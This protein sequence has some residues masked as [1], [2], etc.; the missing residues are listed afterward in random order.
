MAGSTGS[1][2][3]GMGI[4]CVILIKFERE[5]EEARWG[6]AN[7]AEE[8]FAKSRADK[9]L[10]QKWIR[11]RRWWCA[12]RRSYLHVEAWPTHV[13]LRTCAGFRFR[14]YRDRDIFLARNE[15]SSGISFRRANRKSGSCILFSYG[16]REYEMEWKFRTPRRN[17]LHN[18]CSHYSGM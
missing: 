12:L 15:S 8:R 18:S 16:R 5:W 10:F 9:I 13:Y 7:R 6:W 4:C 2:L 17:D 11:C 3:I 14:N 1:A